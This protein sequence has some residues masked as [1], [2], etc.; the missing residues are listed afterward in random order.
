MADKVIVEGRNRVNS[1]RSE[2]LNDAELIGSLENTCRDLGTIDAIDYQVRRSGSEASLLPH[3]AE[4]V[5]YIAREALT[6][7]FRHAGA[8]QIRLE[9]DYDIRYFRMTCTDNGRGFEPAAASRPGHWGL[10][11]MFERAQRVG[12]KLDCR[13]APMKGTDILFKLPAWR[14]YN[15]HSRILFYIRGLSRR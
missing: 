4:E 14:A 3:V 11:G 1:L 7:A 2:Q 15:N 13:S 5:L 9:L 6:N 10:R 12:G 8:S